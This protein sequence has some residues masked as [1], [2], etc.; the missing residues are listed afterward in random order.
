MAVEWSIV[1]ILMQSDVAQYTSDRI[2][3]GN[4]RQQGTYPAVQVDSFSDSINGKCGEVAEE[5]TV[6]VIAWADR[7]YTCEQIINAAKTALIQKDAL[8]TGS[9]IN[10]IEFESRGPWLRDDEKRYWGRP[11]D[12]RVRVT[13]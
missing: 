8:V 9:D 3:S 7:R 11:A 6:T 1:E 5:F 13:P 10:G 2:S 12:F 4:L